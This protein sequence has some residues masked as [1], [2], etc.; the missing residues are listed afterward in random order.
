V[1][2][3][4]R[5]SFSHLFGFAY[6]GLLSHIGLDFLTSFGTAVLWPLSHER[7][8]LAQHYVIDPIFTVLALGFLIAS[9]RLKQRRVSLAHT[10]LL[11]IGLYMVITAAV[12]R[13]AFIRWQEF[14]ELQGILPTRSVVLP[15]FPGPF[16]WLGVS[17][18]EKGFYQQSF[19]LYGSN[20]HA[21]HF[22]SKTNADLRKLERLR[23]VQAFLSFA[24]F[25]WKQESYDRGLRVVEYR[26]LAFADHPLGGPL[27]LRIWLDESGS[28]RKMELGHRF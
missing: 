19:W 11:A 1:W 12:Q 16:H 22:F 5:G 28:I 18:T 6:I 25:P 20:S 2:T 3:F 8:S 26:D 4:R 17:E 9:F 27:A 24:R 7:F 10:G 21:P 14:M 23:E 13:A 15:F